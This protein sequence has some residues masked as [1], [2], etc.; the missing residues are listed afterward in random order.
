MK[1][2]VLGSGNGGCAIAF[3]WASAGH[4]VYLYDFEEFGA[5]IEDINENGGLKSSGDLEGFVELKYAGY[6]IN[7]TIEGAKIIFVVGPA[8]STE[9]FAI[10][11]KD[12]LEDD[13]IVV[14]CPSSCAGA[15][16]FKN[17]IGE[18]YLDKSIT[19]AETSTLPYAVR[20]SDKA[21]I[22][23][24][25]KLKAGFY[26]ATLEKE[27]LENVYEKLRTVYPGIEKAKNVFKTTLQN[28]NPVIHP[29]VSLLNTALIERSGG[30]FLFYE[31]G[32]TKSVG[33]LIKAIDDERIEIGKALGLEIIPDPILGK[34][35]GY[36]AEETYDI[37][38][39]EA[40][41]FKGIKAQSSLD[42]RY[43]HED[44]GY[45]LVFLVSLAQEL[46]V[47]TPAMDSVIE[48]VSI[49]M[50][51]DYYAEEKRTVKNLGL[52]KVEIDKIIN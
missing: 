31:E 2:A 42:N 21:E 33:R 24:F 15:L 51:K 18:V 32:V 41:G 48:L 36:M 20:I 12:Y 46:G 34:R 19:I 28:A 23:V 45:G 17:A 49:V 39:M 47:E 26:L 43:F 52:G 50:D 29:A 16:V 38:F 30:D 3:D 14:V 4:D 6:D 35:Q 22:R 40:P 8:Y 25:L 27:R 37:G 13:Q 1:I 11:A 10:V 9:P 5:N 44:V 7:K